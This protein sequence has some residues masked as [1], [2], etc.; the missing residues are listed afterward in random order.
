MRKRGLALA[1]VA[2][3]LGSPAGAEMVLSDVM[4]DDV[5][6]GRAL[7]GRIEIKV[8]GADRVR[9]T[10]SAAPAMVALRAAGDKSGSQQA[11]EPKVA[12][13][14]GPDRLQV[15]ARLDGPGSV[16]VRETAKLKGSSGPAQAKVHVKAS[17]SGSCSA[18]AKVR[19]ATRR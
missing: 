11:G 12:V 6:A 9:L 7:A 1:L 5:Y 15:T 18:V 14:R 4:L 17:C 8:P 13:E 3:G 19:V 10:P 16:S 2:A